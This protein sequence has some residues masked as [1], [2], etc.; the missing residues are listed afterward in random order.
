MKTAILL[1]SLWLSGSPDP[2]LSYKMV[3]NDQ[4]VSLKRAVYQEPRLYRV[5]PVD[6]RGSVIGDTLQ[7][8]IQHRETPTERLSP[9]YKR[10]DVVIACWPSRIPQSAGREKSVLS[11][12]SGRLA[13]KR[14]GSYLHVLKYSP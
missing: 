8:L 5:V 7:V 14:R 2:G 1:L 13:I 9:L 4:P 11:N 10:A 3:G 12:Y 6:H